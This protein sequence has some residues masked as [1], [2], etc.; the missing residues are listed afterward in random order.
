MASLPDHVRDDLA[1]FALPSLL[2]AGSDNVV[3]AKAPSMAEAASDPNV[4]HRPSAPMMAGGYVDDAVGRRGL[5]FEHEH[6][7]ERR[8]RGQIPRQH[9]PAA[10]PAEG[11][12]KIGRLKVGH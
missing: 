7:V 8:D 11:T 2:R 9:V 12:H 3:F 1:F 5:S 10:C 4:A 6:H